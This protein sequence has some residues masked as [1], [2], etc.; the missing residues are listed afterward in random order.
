MK[1]I[2]SGGG[3]GGHIYPAIAIANELKRRD[4]SSEFLFVGAQDKMEMEKVPA[5]GYKIEGLWISGLQRKFTL[6]NLL[7]PFKVLAS[8]FRAKKIL[9]EFQP[10]VVIGTGGFASGSIVNEAAGQGIKTLIQEQNSYAGL[11]N[12]ILGSKVNTI[13]VAYDGMEKFFPAKK[14]VLTGNPIRKDII[15]IYSKRNQAYKLFKL[16]DEK[17]TLLILGGSLGAGTI[18]KS[19]AAGLDKLKEAK[20]NVLWQTGSYYFETYKNL[21]NEF[22]KVT[23]FIK[24]MDM[25]YAVSDI[26]ISRAGALSISELECT[27]RVCILVPSPNVAEDHQTKNAMSLVNKNAA[28]MISDAEAPAKLVDE[29]LLLFK[30]EKKITELKKNISALAQIDSTEK[31]VDEV[32]KLVNKK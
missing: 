4:P 26:V 8:K 28:I 18:N 17:K 31:I 11:T 1:F 24:E 29:A 7:F 23:D 25:A 12:K 15:N 3:T 5:N 20:I 27:N 2:L 30:N 14:I 10:D 22:I 13:C 9:K 19:I 16:D 21:N 6:D 32:L